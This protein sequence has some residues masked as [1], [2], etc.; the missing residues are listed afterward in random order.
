M[1]FLV[2]DFL[3][4][5]LRSQFYRANKQKKSTNNILDVSVIIFAILYMSKYHNMLIKILFININNV[6]SKKSMS[7]T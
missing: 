7:S 3:E 1:K 2:S 6:L 4:S 5:F